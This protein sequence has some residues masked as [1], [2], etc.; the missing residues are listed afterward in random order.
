M[1]NLFELYKSINTLNKTV[2]ILMINAMNDF[3][4]HLYITTEKREVE[5]QSTNDLIIIDRK[6][7]RLRE[8]SACHF[9]LRTCLM[10]CCNTTLKR[11]TNKQKR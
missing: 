10:I 7:N 4:S 9:A 8:K 2:V 1:N 5:L 6:E 3:F 11:K